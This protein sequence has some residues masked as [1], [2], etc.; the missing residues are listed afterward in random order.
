MFNLICSQSNG[1]SRSAG[2]PAAATAAASEATEGGAPAA[3]L[4]GG[5]DP[6]PVEGEWPAGCEHMFWPPREGHQD[7]REVI[8]TFS[9]RVLVTQQFR[10]APD[11]TFVTKEPVCFSDERKAITLHRVTE[12]E[13]RVVRKQI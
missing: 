10:I 6:D 4:A 7:E 8:L 2:Q 3:G 11:G 9:T 13:P 5:V 12:P 1:D